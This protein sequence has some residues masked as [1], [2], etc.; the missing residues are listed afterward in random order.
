MAGVFEQARQEEALRNHIWNI[1]EPYAKE[2]LTT[3]YVEFTEQ[4]VSEL[5]SEALRI[6][7]LA[8][9]HSFRLPTD[10]FDTLTRLYS[11]DSLPDYRENPLANTPDVIA[12][13]KSFFGS[14]K[15]GPS[16]RSER[17]VLDDTYESFTPH[18]ILIPIMSRVS[19]R[20]TP[21]PGQN[22]S[23]RKLS[24]HQSIDNLLKSTPINLKQVEVENL[25]EPQV[26][27]DSTLDLTLSITAETATAL[28][29]L[30]KSAGALSRPDPN[31]RNP[32]LHTSN[33]PN[34]EKSLDL[35][36][37]IWMSM[38]T[39]GFPTDDGPALGFT[40]I[41]PRSRR[42][43]AARGRKSEPEKGRRA[44]SI[45]SSKSRPGSRSRSRHSASPNPAGTLAPPIPTSMTELVA[46]VEAEK[47]LA[48][49]TA[50]KVI[51]DRPGFQESA[52]KPIDLGIMKVKLEETEGLGIGEGELYKENMVVVNGWQTYVTSSPSKPSSGSTTPASSQE[53]QLD[54]LLNE[55]KS[56][57]DTDL[58]P[59]SALKNSR[60]DV[61]AIPRSR[62]IGGASI[63]KS[64]GAKVKRIGANKRQ[65]HQ[66]VPV[67][68]DEEP[69]TANKTA[70]G[71]GRPQTPTKPGSNLAGNAG[72][73]GIGEESYSPTKSSMIGEPPST[74]GVLVPAPE[75]E[76]ALNLASAT[77]STANI[78]K[79]S[80]GFNSTS[81]VEDF[82]TELLGLYLPT[83]TKEG[84]TKEDG[85]P[86]PIKI[87]LKEKLDEKGSG[88]AGQGPGALLMEVPNLPPPTEHPPNA[89]FLPKGL[90]D[91]I[92]PPASKSKTPMAA[93][94]P[95]GSHQ[96]LKK[97]KGIRPLSLQLSWIPFTVQGGQLPT[98]LEVTGVDLLLNDVQPASH[99][100]M[101][102]EIEMQT[103]MRLSEVK[104]RVNELV[105]SCGT[106]ELEE[107][108]QEDLD[109][110]KEVVAEKLARKHW[111]RWD[112]DLYCE[113][114]VFREDLFRS[115]I[116]LSRE[117]R[118]R[119]SGLGDLL[120]EPITD[121]PDAENSAEKEKT[122]EDPEEILE[123]IEDP[124][125]SEGDGNI[126]DGGDSDKENWEPRQLYRRLGD[127]DDLESDRPRKRP[128]LDAFPDG[129]FS[130]DCDTD[131]ENVLLD[132]HEHKL[133]SDIDDGMLLDE[134]I[135]A[136]SGVGFI[137]QKQDQDFHN[138]AR[139]ER[140]NHQL[141]DDYDYGDNHRPLGGMLGPLR[142]MEGS[143][144][145]EPEARQFQYSLSQE[146]YPF[147]NS[148]PP[149][150]EILPG[151][152]ADEF[153]D[154][155]LDMLDGS[156][157]LQ[158]PGNPG[159]FAFP[160][161]DPSFEAL[162][163]ETQLSQFLNGFDVDLPEDPAQTLAQTQTAS[164][165]P[166]EFDT[167]MV[168]DANT[169]TST[170]SI[171]TIAKEKDSSHDPVSTS[172]PNAK[173]NQNPN[174]SGISLNIEYLNHSA[175]IAEFARLRGKKTIAAHTKNALTSASANVSAGP[176]TVT[177]HSTSASNAKSTEVTSGST[178]ASNPIHA[179]NANSNET[180]KELLNNNDTLQPPPSQN[181][182]TS[183]HWYM[184]SLSLL[185]KQ[186]L[187][188]S[189][190]SPECAVGLVERDSLDGVD[191]ILDPHTAV[192]YIN[193]PGLPAQCDD[194]VKLVKEQSW[195]Y[196]RLLV[197]FEAY[198][199]SISFKAQASSISKSSTSMTMSGS[200][201][202]GVTSTTTINTYSPPVIK[203]IKR[204]RT[205]ISIAE[206]C[207]EKN[208]KCKVYTAFAN[209]VLEAARFS[210]VLGDMVEREDASAKRW[211]GE[212]GKEG[213]EMG[214]GGL[215]WGERKWL[216]DDVP[217]AEE[218][219]AAA[220]G[221]NRFAAYVILCQISVEDFLEMMPEERLERFGP[222]IGDERIVTLN[223]VI[224]ERMRALEQSEVGYEDRYA[225]GDGMGI[226]RERDGVA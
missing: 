84:L 143:K 155:S 135:F 194:V 13:L 22:E 163:L 183:P 46:P 49:A 130:R 190:R 94:E 85:V 87:I 105:K 111:K 39:A 145:F 43:G 205:H 21:R 223:R 78:T 96:Y 178:A 147:Y 80:S 68:E 123:D 146:P 136:D 72:G 97:V 224:D 14:L 23:R 160:Q 12:Y 104:K 109:G 24:E 215:L 207:G 166:P 171:S 170:S 55:W 218:N 120:E 61:P 159:P 30:L 219:V 211:T 90:E 4:S 9:S 202:E 42:V 161:H 15:S 79:L 115:E 81:V 124:M 158:E 179:S 220:E 118:R 181:L 152:S 17:A 214:T 19:R 6:V 29:S 157:L 18:E 58:S 119:L 162:N 98:D 125:T 210:R 206:G 52:A 2:H 151:H 133:G 164:R 200:A 34:S 172:R 88:P 139:L 177:P 77:A 59:I 142:G 186:G 150:E 153:L 196:N 20:A 67:P 65:N 102:M 132:G 89:L 191:L 31:Y 226:E 144:S 27:V 198:L 213:E 168:P 56:S 41:F 187:I 60:M 185:Q 73:T 7:P 197:V 174:L 66:K 28:K 3:D 92:L 86:D 169:C 134:D 107:Q 63:T 167:Q 82:G 38:S 129:H 165:Q 54:Q 212:W 44:D 57:P 48:V 74:L 221:M 131:G 203:S 199:P 154:D 204:F 201:L 47:F 208:T 192:I 113:H 10:P 99:D 112:R 121:V 11:L 40:P 76:S 75:P 110:E 35:V 188:R 114:G 117:E 149:P 37:G 1:L 64:E 189:L 156:L 141:S 138:L 175:G 195:R 222:F 137:P 101:S 176:S 225:D 53:D 71:T 62:R 5:L 93:A 128:K 217:D 70:A 32:Y 83:L 69:E 148:L 184:A 36:P 216:G 209:T 180:P 25:T 126:V 100:K 193:L 33:P 106:G 140:D 173:P 122:Q 8:D 182:P 95:T 45:G 116:V 50:S 103:G 16:S 91:F 51:S 26:D 108:E 127:D